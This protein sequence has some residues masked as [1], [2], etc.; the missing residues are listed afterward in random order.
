MN[1]RI[2]II[3]P[4]F[5]GHFANYFSLFLKSCAANPE[6]DWF[7]FTDN[8]DEY[9]YPENV[10]KIKMTYEEAKVL[11]QAKFDFPIVINSPVKLHDYKPAFGYIFSDY[12]TEYD[13]WGYSDYDV[14]YGNLSQF[15]TDDMLDK[16]DKLFRMGH[17]S[18]YRNDDQCNRIFM[19]T[20]N[21]FS[22]FMKVAQCENNCNF[23]DDWNGITNIYNL[24]EQAGKRIYENPENESKIADIYD[25]SSDFKVTYQRR[26]EW[27]DNVEEKK[28]AFFAFKEGK[29]LRYCIGSKGYYVEEYMYLHLHNRK[30]QINDGVIDANDF[31]IIP[32]AFITFPTKITYENIGKIRVKYPNMHYFRLRYKNLRIKLKNRL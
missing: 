16:Y 31:G 28:R 17:F 32:N 18:I 1:K 29:L 30:M 3:R 4:F 22:P 23:D 9:V 21:G 7:L 8:D 5:K 19:D 6:F 24:F 2:A 10:H 20:I 15:I 27:K 11:F 26:G 13:F 14:I 25:K 12:L